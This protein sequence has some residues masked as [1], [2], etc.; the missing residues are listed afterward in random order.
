M[1]RLPDTA[2][3]APDTTTVALTCRDVPGSRLTATDDWAYGSPVCGSVYWPPMIPAA[4][5]S[6]HVA[7][8]SPDYIT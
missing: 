2:T 1:V 3:L 7:P 8:P 6:F 5:S 4:A